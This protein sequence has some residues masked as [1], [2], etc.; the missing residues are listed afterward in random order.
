[1]VGIGR[2]TPM[3]DIFP[4]QLERESWDLRNKD[5]PFVNQTP[6]AMAEIVAKSRLLNDLVAEKARAAAQHV[7]TAVVCADMLSI[8]KAHGMG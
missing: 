4:H 8:V 2:T 1:M 5:A 7:N 6:S 3:V